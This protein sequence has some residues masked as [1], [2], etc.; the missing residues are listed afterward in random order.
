MIT[1]Q[2]N[3]IKIGIPPGYASTEL[4]SRLLSSVFLILNSEFCLLNSVRPICPLPPSP[5]KSPVAG[6]RPVNKKSSSDNVPVRNKSPITTVK[7]VCAV[8]AECKKGSRLH[9]DR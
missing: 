2:H 6:E 1:N 7:A 8:V 9:R 5:D 4:S 3:V